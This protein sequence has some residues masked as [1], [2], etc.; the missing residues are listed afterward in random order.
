MTKNF[1]QQELMTQYVM[2]EYHKVVIQHKHGH[3]AML[4]LN[5]Q[6]DKI[7]AQSKYDFETD[8]VQ[9]PND[10][11]EA[12]HRRRP[13]RVNMEDNMVSTKRL[14]LVFLHKSKHPNKYGIDDHHNTLKSNT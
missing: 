5:Q 14:D 2:D 6:L 8:K 4:R 9:V 11:L 12:C 3:T 7:I 13:N 10:I 1:T